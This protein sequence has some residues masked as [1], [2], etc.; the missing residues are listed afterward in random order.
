MACI[1][2]N[3]ASDPPNTNYILVSAA[4]STGYSCSNNAYLKHISPECRF[5]PEALT[6]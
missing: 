6:L 1:F 3:I 4:D 5:T 2:A